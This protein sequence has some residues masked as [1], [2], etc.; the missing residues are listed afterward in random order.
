M[1]LDF[2]RRWRRVTEP[3]LPSTSVTGQYSKSD[4]ST[5]D[6][7]R[8]LTGRC[9]GGGNKIMLDKK[10]R[11][12]STGSSDNNLIDVFDKKQSVIPNPWNSLRRS[13]VANVTHKEA[14][15]Q[16]T[17]NKDSIIL[18]KCTRAGLY[19][20]S[21]S[22]LHTTDNQDSHQTNRRSEGNTYLETGADVLQYTNWDTFGS[23]ITLNFGDEFSARQHFNKRKSFSNGRESHSFQNTF[24]EATSDCDSD[25]YE[26]INWN[27]D[28]GNYYDSDSGISSLYE[29][30][31]KYQTLPR[32]TCNRNSFVLPKTID[33]NEESDN[34]NNFLDHNLEKL[35]VDP[36]LFHLFHRNYRAVHTSAVFAMDF[37]VLTRASV[38]T[39]H[40]ITL[41]GNSSE[42]KRTLLKAVTKQQQVFSSLI[43]KMKAEKAD[44]D[45]SLRFIEEYLVNEADNVIV[46]KY[47]RFLDQTDSL[48]NLIFG[49]ELKI[50]NLLNSS[51]NA[52]PWK[53]R[54]EEAIM[55]KDMHDE[56]FHLILN[57]LDASNQCV[58]KDGLELKRKLICE[59]RI[60][61]QELFYLEMQLRILFM[62]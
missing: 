33:E 45:N 43:K 8:T 51:N 31:I 19:L 52:N 54:L 2:L 20:S 32:T 42:I 53:V 46:K 11:R 41:R 13:K 16:D 60:V 37:D 12:V 29:T 22:L 21:P 23:V 4:E 62:Y 57:Q 59:I 18:T 44:V 56:T 9:G 40:V 38:I 7:D 28:S 14:A 10:A 50:A 61:N 17:R 47:N 36:K 58:L 34:E 26:D 5:G 3:E 35:K 27:E 39:N 15:K 25:I 24:I 1:V 48:V 6:N 55:I 30:I 49:L